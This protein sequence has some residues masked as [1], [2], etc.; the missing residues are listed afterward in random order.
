M[1]QAGIALVAALFLI[2]GLAVLAALTLRA[3]SHVADARNLEMLDDLAEL[4]ATAGIEWGAYRVLRLGAA[5]P[6]DLVLPALPGTLAKFSVRVQCQPMPP[7][8]W[9]IT[10]TARQGNDPR[11]GDY[12]ERSLS[13]EVRP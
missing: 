8:G 12:A 6:F 1:K 5:C 10:A 11:Q 9:R 7:A 4:A 2:V 13:L 3:S